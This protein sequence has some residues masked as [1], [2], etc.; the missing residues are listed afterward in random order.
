MPFD[1]DEVPEDAFSTEALSAKVRAEQG[2][3]PAEEAPPEGEVVLEAKDEQPR[4][5]E[6]GRFAPKEEPLLGKFKSVDDLAKAYQELERYRGEVSAEL[7]ELRQQSQQ[8]QAFLHQQQPGLGQVQQLREDGEYQQAASLALRA[9]DHYTYESVLREWGEQEPYE[10]ANFRFEVRLAQMHQQFAEQQ[11]PL[12]QQMHDQ[13]LVSAL[14]NVTRKFPDVEAED[15]LA[16]AESAPGLL[17]GLRDGGIQEAEQMFENLAWLARGRKADEAAVEAQK[18]TA[19]QAEAN[20]QARV[21]AVVASASSNSATR[22]EKSPIDEWKRKVFH[23]ESPN[24]L[25]LGLG[26]D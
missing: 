5:P 7:G 17:Y 14:G 13:L 12:Q 26:Q 20:D 18:I 10:A 16:A 15:I 9:G 1:E 25:R 2:E 21:E 24:S 6:T 19:E 22:E 11:Q 8:W 3:P 23:T 4:D